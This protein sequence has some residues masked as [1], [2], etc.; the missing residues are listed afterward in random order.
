MEGAVQTEFNKKLCFLVLLACTALRLRLHGESWPFVHSHRFPRLAHPKLREASSQVRRQASGIPTYKQA[1]MTFRLKDLQDACMEMGMSP[2]VRHVS[3]KELVQA[4]C[5]VRLPLSALK[6]AVKKVKA[7]H[8]QQ[9]RREALMAFKPDELR[10]AVRLLGESRCNNWNKGQCVSFLKKS[11]VT[12]RDVQAYI[13]AQRHNDPDPSQARQQQKKRG[14]RS[15]RQSW[16][17]RDW[18]DIEPEDYDDV[19]QWISSNDFMDSDLYEEA[20]H[21]RNSRSRFQEVYPSGFEDFY[22]SPEHA[23]TYS[24][25]SGDSPWVED[26]VA[27]ERAMDTAVRE[28]WDT[29]SLSRSQASRLLGVTQCPGEEELRQ[30]RKALVR[31]WHP[32]RH[33]G[34]ELGAQRF[35]L[36]IAACEVLS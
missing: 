5:K 22:F 25:N 15:R 16:R 4:I 24:A 21:S 35:R 28:S 31:K 29:S 10:F 26:R 19:E 23:S 14:R 33:P 18:S 1:V 11:G 8:K 36:V 34:D 2:Q 3:K 12:A 30:A 13:K 7:A 32:D 20:V 27:L 17:S 6:S 9:Q